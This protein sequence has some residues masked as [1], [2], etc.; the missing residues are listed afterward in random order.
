MELKLLKLVGVLCLLYFCGSYN[1]FFR[2]MDS[3]FPSNTSIR[4]S[5]EGRI[6]LVVL[7]DNKFFVNPCSTKVVHEVSSFMPSA[8]LNDSI[9]RKQNQCYLCINKLF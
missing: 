3:S 2:T 6:H 5:I 7:P 8:S 1:G 9:W 4:K